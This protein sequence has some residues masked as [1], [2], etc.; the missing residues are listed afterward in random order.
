VYIYIKY[1]NS[2][3]LLSKKK[4]Q[5]KTKTKQ[6]MN[7]TNIVNSPN[8]CLFYR[9]VKS[10]EWNKKKKQI[11]IRSCVCGLFF[12]KNNV[13]EKLGL[14][15]RWRRRRNEEQSKKTWHKIFFLWSIR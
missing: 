11:T 15:K 6:R 3:V 14:K 13:K 10:R 8:I 7:T 4:L 9:V 1:C 5:K 12:S 2:L